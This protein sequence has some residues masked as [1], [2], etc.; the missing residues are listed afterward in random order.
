[1]IARR[2]VQSLKRQD[3]MMVSI[4]FALVVVG[5]LL[6]F[7]IND[8][9]NARAEVGA[10][11]KAAERLLDEAEQDIASVKE[12]K[13]FLD[14]V[15]GNLS[16][17][18][19]RL[20]RKSWAAADERR[21]HDGLMT[22]RFMAAMVPPTS[23]YNELISDGSFSNIASPKVRASI[24]RFHSTLDYDERTRQ[25][26]LPVLQEYESIPSLHYRVDPLAIKPP[27]LTVDYRSLA[28]DPDGQRILAVTTGHLFGLRWDRQRALRESIMMCRALAQ[29]LQRTC[30][31]HRPLPV[32]D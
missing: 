30:N 2:V 13:I 27:E 23:V 5:V 12:A 16:F 1:M 22:G 25:Q 28:N 3:W 9:A 20:A 17:A 11:R 26:F 31:E 18:L 19:D 24:S 21:M 6:A 14:G 32:F 10:Q 15:I 8:W 7:Q 29:S 4:E